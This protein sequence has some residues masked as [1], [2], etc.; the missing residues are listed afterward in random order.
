MAKDYA[1]K[2]MFNQ[3]RSSKR[4]RDQTKRTGLLAFFAGSCLLG[5]AII[6][7]MHLSHGKVT[8]WSESI[9]NAFKHHDKM[10]AKAPNAQAAPAQNEDVHFDFYTELPNMRVAL[11]AS[12]STETVKT[13][14]RPPQTVGQVDESIKSVIDS[15]KTPT[16]IIVQLG[17]FKDPLNASQLRLS[18][19]LAGIETEVVKTATHTYRVQ[20]GPYSSERQ[21]KAAQQQLNKKGFDSMIKNAL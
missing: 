14:S 5:A 9:F 17:E 18:L 3:R 8:I 11:P 16:Q 6:Y 12:A 4:G 21:A 10:Q 20:K 13:I 1:N 7:G 2:K 19:L 15:R